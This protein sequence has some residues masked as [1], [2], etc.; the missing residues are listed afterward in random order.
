ML[1]VVCLLISVES[2]YTGQVILSDGTICDE[3]SYGGIIPVLIGNGYDA[4]EMLDRG[5]QIPRF[6]VKRVRIIDGLAVP[7]MD[8]N[9]KKCIRMYS[10]EEFYVSEVS[11]R[12]LMPGESL[13]RWVNMVDAN[14]NKIGFIVTDENRKNTGINNT[15]KLW[16]IEKK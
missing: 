9:T 12:L 7:T 8:A 13:V 6:K 10:N 15:V 11:A 16:Q 2:G 4:I 3:K 1:I 14:G 5:K